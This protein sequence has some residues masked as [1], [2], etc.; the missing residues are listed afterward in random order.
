M[1][2][3]TLTC[4]VRWNALHCNRAPNLLIG[5]REKSS[6][7]T[8]VQEPLGAYGLSIAG[9]AEPDRLVRLPIDRPVR[10]LQVRCQPTVDS[11]DDVE[12]PGT[13]VMDLLGGGRVALDRGTRSAV[14]SGL[15]SGDDRLVHPGL[16][17]AGSV[18]AWWDGYETMH[19]GAAVGSDGDAWMLLGDRGAG[20]SSTLARLHAR[21]IPILT[22]DLVVL[23][24]NGV[25]AGPRCLDLRADAVKPLGLAHLASARGGER[26]R[27]SLGPC[28][29]AAIL[30]GWISLSWGDR[31]QARALTPGQR[32]RR[33]ERQRGVR[34]RGARGIAPADLGGLLDLARLPAWEIT[35]PQQWASMDAA[36][37]RVLEIIA[38]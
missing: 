5:P 37:G 30:R 15:S 13:L 24:G 22:D 12:K 20:K 10:P 1:V 23:E 38:G 16:A 36:V 25:L 28:P 26:H 27:L 19:A 18:F 33:L 31:T 29:P 35:R 14:F 9:L 4:L 32:L 11:A 17:L 3:R 8:V 6:G 2:L 7:P 34:G 21:G